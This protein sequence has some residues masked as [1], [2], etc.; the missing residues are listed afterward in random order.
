[1]RGRKRSCGPEDRRAKWRFA[2]NEELRYKL[3]SGDRVTETGTGWTQN[4][5]SS[6]ISFVTDAILDIGAL[7]ELSVSWPVRLDDICPIQLMIYGSVV[8]SDP[9]GT[10]ML[11]ERYEF[12]TRRST[13]EPLYEETGF[14]LPA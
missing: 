2:I 8:R 10:A 3:L 13:A 14:R 12:R 6:G 11:I 7:V 1:M 4:I 5:S 9:T